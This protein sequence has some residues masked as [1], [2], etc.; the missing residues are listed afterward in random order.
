[1]DMNIWEMFLL[2][3]LIWVLFPIWLGAIVRVVCASWYRAQR[4]HVKQIIT[5]DIING[6]ETCEDNK[7]N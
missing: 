7:E 4:D 5:E 2:I 6:K 1:M 3:V